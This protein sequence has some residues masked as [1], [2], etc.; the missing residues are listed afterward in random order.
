MRWTERSN[1]GCPA[2]RGACSSLTFGAAGPYSVGTL[3]PRVLIDTEPQVSWAPDERE[4]A[5]PERAQSNGT[6]GLDTGPGPGRATRPA[7]PAT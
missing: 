7:R 6:S 3:T 4:E 5:H 2:S 1:V